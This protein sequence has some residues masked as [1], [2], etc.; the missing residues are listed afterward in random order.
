[1]IESQGCRHLEAFMRP[2]CV[3]LTV[4]TF[5]DVPEP[6]PNPSASLRATL[7]RMLAAATSD[8]WTT[9]KL[10]VRLTYATVGWQTVEL[11]PSHRRLEAHGQ[12]LAWPRLCLTGHIQ[13]GCC[14]HLDNDADNDNNWCCPVQHARITRRPWA[15]KAIHAS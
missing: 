10:V 2:G 9:T 12:S 5:R 14:Q 4:D 6:A 13:A 11:L 3:F 7:E 15:S 8:F 1:M